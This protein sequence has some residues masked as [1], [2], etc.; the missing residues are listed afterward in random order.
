MGNGDQ[1]PYVFFY[2]SYKNEPPNKKRITIFDQ[3]WNFW[4]LE[5]KFD[6]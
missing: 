1:E 2:I 5:A 4:N 3:K 6:K